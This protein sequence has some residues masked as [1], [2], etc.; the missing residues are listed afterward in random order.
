PTPSCF[1]TSRK[2]SGAL[3]YFCVEL[4]EMTLRAAILESRVKISSWIPSAKYALDFSSLRLSNGRTAMLLPGIS[5]AAFDPVD[6]KTAA[7]LG[8][9]E[10]RSR[11]ARRP[12]AAT[13]STIVSATIFRPVWGVME[14]SGSISD[15]RLMP[16]GVISNAHDKSRQ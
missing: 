11:N 9:F 1:P 15:S 2:L 14:L 7:A 16:S 5:T 12:A 4:R 8:D 13:P 3:L 10:R 6:G